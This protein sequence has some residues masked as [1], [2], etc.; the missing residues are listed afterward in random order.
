MA[1]HCLDRAARLGGAVALFEEGL[2]FLEGGFGAGGQATGVA[3]F[4]RAAE[5]GHPEAAFRLAEALRTGHGCP[6][7][8]AQ[9][10]VWYQRAATAGCGPAAIWLAQAYA[11]GDGV[12]PDAEHARHWSGV[13]ERL[14]PHAP[15]RCSLLRHDAAPEDVLVRAGAQAA[16]HV[17]AAAGLVVAHRT[18][19]WVLGLGAMVLAC[20]SLGTVGILFWAGSS[21]LFHLP[22]LMLAPPALMLAWQAW[23]LRREGPREGRDRLHEAAEG[24]DPEACYRLG[25]AYQSG[26]GH[27]PKDGLSAALWYRRAAEAGHRGAMA[28]LAEAYLGGHGVLRDPREAARWRE[29]ARQELPG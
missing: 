17:E 10:E 4:R 21:G 8:P 27:R 1:H 13:A 11:E 29:A 6:R 18:G 7:D 16:A 2:A 25:L 12:M 24:G 26:S 28:A 15:L 19:R 9:A 22:L 5:L 20:L 14:R 3:R 23:R